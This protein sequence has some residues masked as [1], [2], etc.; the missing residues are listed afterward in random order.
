MRLAKPQLYIEFRDG[1]NFIVLG[2]F[3]TADIQGV[4]P[5]EWVCYEVQTEELEF[6]KIL[7]PWYHGVRAMSPIGGNNDD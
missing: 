5:L 7:V 4:K 1:D 6:K 3:Y 2:P